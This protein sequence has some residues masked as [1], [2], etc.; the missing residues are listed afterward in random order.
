MP[1]A[2]FV[3]LR[4]HTAYSLSEG[5]LPIAELVQLCH[6]RGMP[7]V[8]ITD[9]NNL[10]GAA[11]FSAAAA[12]AGVQPIIGC[13]LSVTREDPTGGREP[14]NGNGNGHHGRSRDSDPLVL[15]V[16]DSAG[17]HNLL[18]LIR[19]AYLGDEDA[20]DAQVPPAA[21]E[22]HAGGLI[23]LTGGPDGPVGR[24]LQDGQNDA[25]R[26]LAER[27]KAAFPGRLYVE[28]M[29]HGL[30]S[31]KETEPQFLDLAYALDLPLV[32][33]NEAFFADAD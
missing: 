5:A 10:F 15:L 6:A 18:K 3:H 14:L 31:E 12:K 19:R 8:A 9:T 24:L 4:V 11:E 13:Q 25:A 1:H 21:L 33:T 30:N 23:A 28:L 29:R 20:H 26:A 22:E 32:A 16:Q 17:Y 7:A 2:D 27:L